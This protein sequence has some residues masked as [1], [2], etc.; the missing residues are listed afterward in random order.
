MDEQA[1]KE[2]LKG[3]GGTPA[4]DLQQNIL[5]RE[6]LRVFINTLKIQAATGEPM[7]KERMLEML[8][9]GTEAL[10]D[11][12]T[13]QQKAARL[14]YF[15]REVADQTQEYMKSKDGEKGAQ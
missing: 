15:L 8:Q 12:Q 5:I 10:S 7:P 9:I 14:S 3:A 6:T 13:M 2:A 1:W 11:G 4:D